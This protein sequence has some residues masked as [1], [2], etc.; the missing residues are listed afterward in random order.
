MFAPRAPLCGV[1]KKILEKAH[2]NEFYREQRTKILSSIFAPNM[3]P[4][5]LTSTC[6]TLYINSGVFHQVRSIHLSIHLVLCVCV[7]TCL[8]DGNYYF[9]FLN[10][11]RISILNFHPSINHSAAKYEGVN[12]D[13]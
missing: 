11:V 9:F 6:N 4:I 1:M 12:S 10:S 5:L 8:R 2:L 3:D 13:I 7:C